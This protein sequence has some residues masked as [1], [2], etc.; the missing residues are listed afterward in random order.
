MTDRTGESQVKWYA[1]HVRSNH[2]RVCSTFLEDR[3]VKVFFP[4]YTVRS[5]RADRKVTL[6]KPLFTGYLFV[7]LNLRSKERIQ[8][9][10][11]PGTV[12]I[13]GFGENAT[14]VEEQTIES[15][16]QVVLTV[17][18]RNPNA[19]AWLSGCHGSSPCP[20]GQP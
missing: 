7:H 9:L 14:P 6:T 8:V 10:K 12:R 1:V 16:P 18:H 19:H 4:T 3:N 17:V 20:L 2:E 5:R 11:A 13:V 15:L